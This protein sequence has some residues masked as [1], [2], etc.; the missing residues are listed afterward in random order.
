MTRRSE[1]TPLLNDI[2]IAASELGA[3]LFRQNSGMAWV[4][5]AEPVRSRS[6]VVVNPGDV[7]I[8]RAR[9]FRAGFAGISD[10][11]GWH[12]VEVQ[13]HMVGDKIAVALQVEVKDLAM[14]TDEQLRWIQ[15]VQRAGGI[16]GVVH[17]PQELKA[18]IDARLRSRI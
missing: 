6:A 5:K 15:I 17:N 11:G 4:G 16:A 18:L 8:R 13:P 7:V 2:R 14:P 12:T 3:R 1:E 9:A 10:L